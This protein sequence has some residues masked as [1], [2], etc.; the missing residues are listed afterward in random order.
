M[1]VFVTGATGFI[2]TAL[3]PELLSAGH[4]VLGLTRSQ[5]GADALIKMG[6]E[7]HFGTLEDLGSLQA[8]AAQADGVIHLAFNHDFSRFAENCADDQRAIEAIGDALAGTGKPLIGTGG[9]INIDQAPGKPMDEDDT[10]LPGR[11]PRASEPATLATVENGVRG[12]VLRLSQ[13]HDTRKQGLIQFLIPTALEKKVSLYVGDGS[14]RWAAAHVSDTARLYRLALEQGTAGSKWHAVSEQGVT[15]KEIA[16][17]LGRRLGLPTASISPEEA[18]A[19]FGFLGAFMTVDSPTCN[20]KTR[21]RLGWEPTGPGL[22]A[23]L[24]RLEFAA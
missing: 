14:S 20:T 10:L 18:P 17:A 24:D 13:I 1:R 11:F 3:I 7:A 12:M 16:E 15:Q 9:V 4:T 22:I 8:G 23:D 21:E 19:H 2:G 5:Q 6:A